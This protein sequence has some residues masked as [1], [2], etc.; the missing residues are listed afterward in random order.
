MWIAVGVLPYP[1]TFLCTDRLSELYGRRRASQVVWMGL[2]LNLWLVFILWLGGVLPGVD[3]GADRTP[4][5][6]VF[7]EVR[8]LTFAAVTASMVAYLSAQFVDV[9]L[10]HFWKRLTRGKHLWLRNNASTLV[11]QLVDTIAVIL[12]THFLAQGLPISAARSLWPQL[13]AFIVAGYSFKLLV[14]LADT[15]PFYAAVHYL[16]RYLRLPPP[17]VAHDAE[18]AD[19]VGADSKSG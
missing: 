3:A 12:V 10:F 8:L 4:P 18:A 7:T 1:V 15:G 6:H 5:I 2:A 17:G 13:L 11:S 14:A 19:E 16:T 9:Y